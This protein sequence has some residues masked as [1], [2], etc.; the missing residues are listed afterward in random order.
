MPLGGKTPALNKRLL[1]YEPYVKAYLSA[2]LQN[3][4]LVEELF[5]E[6]ALVVLA[7][8]KTSPDLQVENFQA[9]SKEIARRVVL[10]YFKTQKRNKHV[11]IGDEIEVI[12]NAFSRLAESNAEETTKERCS[13]LLRCVKSLPRHLQDLLFLRFQKNRSLKQIAESQER[14]EGAIQVALSRVRKTL[15]DCMRKSGGKDE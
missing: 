13:K 9:W 6:V 1:D 11:F 10:Q 15:L 8:Q 7:K 2:L 5:Q 14:T 3:T 4:E 12:D